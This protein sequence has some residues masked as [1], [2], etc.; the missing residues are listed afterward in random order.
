MSFLGGYLYFNFKFYLQ[1]A[2]R[3][4]KNLVVG[5]FFREK[6]S[7][8]KVFINERGSLLLAILLD[9]V[10]NS[11]SGKEFL[12]VFKIHLYLF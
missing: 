3:Q 6:L 1:K 10:F 4:V 7:A 11:L 12:Y 9:K 8:W 5:K 2:N